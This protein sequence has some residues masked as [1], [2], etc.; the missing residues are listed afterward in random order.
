[1]APRANALVAYSSVM[2][3]DYQS[4][5][6]VAPYLV[7]AVGRKIVDLGGNVE[8]GGCVVFVAS[9]PY[10]PYIF[11]APTFK[12][13]GNSMILGTIEIMSE[14]YTLAEKSGIGADNMHTIVKG[15]SHSSSRRSASHLFLITEL[16]PA[17]G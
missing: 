2:S 10:N 3:G 16:F 5:K 17:P 12:L 15:M 6:E 11:K 7:P 4:K 13:V 1:M 8:K 9:R 14:A